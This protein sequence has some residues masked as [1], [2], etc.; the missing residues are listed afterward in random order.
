[1]M[2][3]PKPRLIYSPDGLWH[4]RWRT[5]WAIGTTPADAYD[6]WHD[7]YTGFVS[8]KEREARRNFYFKVIGLVFGIPLVWLLFWAVIHFREL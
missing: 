2:N 4:C 5:W 7:R 1:M 3:V 6:L 8:Y